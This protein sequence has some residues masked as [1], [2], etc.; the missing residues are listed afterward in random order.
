[1]Y[2][3]KVRLAGM[4]KTKREKRQKKDRKKNRYATSFIPPFSFT[5]GRASR[6]VLE[7]IL[8]KNSLVRPGRIC[9]VAC[10]VT[11]Q[12]ST[13]PSGGQTPKEHVKE[14]SGGGRG[15]KEQ[16]AAA[17]AARRRRRAS[18]EPG[19]VLRQKRLTN[20]PRTLTPSLPSYP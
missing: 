16:I 15:T 18:G 20:T 11:V 3:C 17:V 14:G 2:L 8:A 4:S 10:R 1:M 6:T 7:G 13:T 19:A 5:V 12:G 9:A